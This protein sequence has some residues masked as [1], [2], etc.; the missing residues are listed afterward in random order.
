MPCHKSELT[1]CEVQALRTDECTLNVTC[2]ST[3]S[4]HSVC[5]TS[6]SSVFKEKVEESDYTCCGLTI[7]A[8]IGI[9]VAVVVVIIVIII[10][11]ICKARGGSDSSE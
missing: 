1:E 4:D 2:D 3:S 8:F 9:M 7:A 10:V 5:F 11:I 6:G